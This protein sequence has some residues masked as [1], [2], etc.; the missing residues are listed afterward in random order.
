M[1]FSGNPQRLNPN[2]HAALIFAFACVLSSGFEDLG[3]RGSGFRA[4][5]WAAL[6]LRC[7]SGNPKVVLNLNPDLDP[8][9]PTF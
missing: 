2:K 3:F 8:Q 7:F 1:L 9:K 6:K 4:R 5:T